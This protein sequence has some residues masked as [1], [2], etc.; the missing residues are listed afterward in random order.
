MK[1]L[2]FKDVAFM[3]NELQKKGY[4]IEEIMLMPVCVGEQEKV[5]ETN[6]EKLL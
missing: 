4:K 1:E 2:T 6:K 3:F 5:N